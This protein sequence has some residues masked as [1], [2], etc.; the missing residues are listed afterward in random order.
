[1][2]TTQLP[3]AALLPRRWLVGLAVVALLISLLVTVR[4]TSDERLQ[5]WMAA[6]TAERGS[7][8]VLARHDSNP[9]ITESDDPTYQCRDPGGRLLDTWR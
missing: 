3:V 4:A 9:L 2:T 5:A 1:M 8:R 7:V 6:C